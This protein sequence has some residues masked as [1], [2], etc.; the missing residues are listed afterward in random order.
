[1]FEEK[2]IMS[3]YLAYGML[4][5][6]IA[7][8]YYTFMTMHI[9]TP[10]KNSLTPEQLK[11]KAEAAYTRGNI[12]YQGIVVGIILIFIFKPFADCKN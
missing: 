5:Y 1:M 3:I 2:C 7:S 11:I 6:T 9:G 4:A 12:F 10:F 8:I